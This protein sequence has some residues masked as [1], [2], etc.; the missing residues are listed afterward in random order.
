MMLFEERIYTAFF[1]FGGIAGGAIG[2]Q[3]SRNEYRGVKAKFHVLGS[4]DCDPLA[5]ADFEMFTGVP[6]TQLDLF[7]REDYIAFHG[8]EPPAGWREATPEDI[9]RASGGICP[10]VVFLSAPCKGFSALLPE[11]SANSEKYQALNRLTVRGMKLCLE[12]FKDNLP[13][14]FIFENVPRITVRGKD[15]LKT[16]KNMLTKAGYE[17]HPKDDKDGYHDCGVIGGLGQHRRRYLM[18][19]RN[20][21]KVKN[22][23]YQP[24]EL[25]VKSIGEIIGPLPLPGDSAGGPM[26]QCPNMEWKTAVRLACIGQGQDWRV[27]EDFPYEQYRI[28]PVC[29]DQFKHSY[30][31]HRFDQPAGTVTGAG[32]PSNGAICVADPR[33]KY[34]PR[35]GA[36]QVGD[37]TKPAGTIIGNA[38]VGGSNGMAAVSD[39]R[40]KERVSRHP[41]TYKVVKFD[42]PAPCV[43]GTRIGSGA[44]V[45]SDPR[46][47]FKPGTHHNIYRICRFDEPARTVTGA[48]GPNNGALSVA[49]PRLGCSC[50][51]GSYG[52]MDWNKPGVTV[53]GS[54]DI[55][56]GCAA[57]ADPRIPADNEKGVW[58]IISE[59]GTW[60]RPLTTWELLAIQSFP[61]YMPDGSPVVLAGKSDAR[62]RE[63]I[64]NAVPP[65]AAMTIGDEILRT[66]LLNEFGEW[67]LSATPIW[68]L[69]EHE[70]HYITA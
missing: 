45:I 20:T 7:S 51:N 29:G 24:P 52:V 13:A 28:V 33:L 14:F 57:V 8:H 30:R 63:R 17:I 3:A 59:D 26:H 27:L 62:H 4:V 44:V 70:N 39:P 35:K 42:G 34:K 66:L 37:W 68:V 12:A 47:N 46:T 69:P 54:I 21:A 18:L 5:C 40:L 50:R 19:S 61:L 15:L 55:H 32:S 9:L 36:F 67:E 11:K 1:L 38:R 49:D 64:G 22:F 25:R 53:T 41:S 43:T 6:A 65:L 56:A 23:L 16:I 10:D 48:L 2:M 58:I 31:V 60:H